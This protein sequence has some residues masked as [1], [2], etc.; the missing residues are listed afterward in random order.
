[1]GWKR[2]WVGVCLLAVIASAASAQEVRESSREIS[3]IRGGIYKVTEGEHATVFLVTSAGIVLVDPPN[4]DLAHWLKTE[5]AQRFP[6]KPIRYVVATSHRYE[7]AAGT[8]VFAANVEFVGHA[9]FHSARKQAATSMPASW[10]TTNDRN[11]ARV[12]SP[13]EAWGDVA[14]PN[15]T[16]R[17]RY[18]IELGGERIELVHPGDGL[19]ADLTLVL[20]PRERILFAAG[21]PLNETPA[22]FGPASPDAYIESLRQ[23]EWLRVDTVISERGEMWTLSDVALVRQYLVAM[24]N[25]VRQGFGNGDAVE[26]V[27]ADLTL[28]RFRQLRGFDT[29]RGANIAETYRRLRVITVGLT[30]AGEFVHVQRGIPY[31]AADAIP[32]IQLSCQGVGGGTFG[33]TVAASLMAGRVG[34]AVEL[35]GTGLVKGSDQIF[36]QVPRSYE[37]RDA[38]TAV[39]FRYRATPSDRTGLVLTAGMARITA[40]KR[41]SSVEFPSA[42]DFDTTRMTQMY[43]ADILAPVG[44]LKFVIPVRVTHVPA[45]L[46]SGI[47]VTAPKWNV[48]LG[49]GLAVA[50][51]GVR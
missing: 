13:V 32:T 19:G 23:V 50:I 36:R 28:D 29:R 34:G 11:G 2:A 16:Y 48:R 25:G 1:M 8:G 31:C 26:R 7:R 21:V 33:A 3:E 4:R 40:T 39:M 42:S 47:G 27:Q 20:F 51:K 12:V 14:V 18:S 45:G 17:D 24:V 37:Y 41:M 5:L 46:Y 22:S 6:G 44:S 38:V 30:A 35:G 43:G 10:K 49:L 15:K 9:N